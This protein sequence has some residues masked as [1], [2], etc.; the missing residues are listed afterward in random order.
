MICFSVVNSFWGRRGVTRIFYV[1]MSKRPKILSQQELQDA[2]N[3][4]VGG[5]VKV[6]YFTRPDLYDE[7]VG[8]L[9]IEAGAAFIDAADRHGN[10]SRQNI[11]R[12]GAAIVGV[13][14]VAPPQAAAAADSAPAP[15]SRP[16]TPTDEAANQQRLAIFQ[17]ATRAA[18]EATQQRAKQAAEA[19]Q[20][21]DRHA[22]ATASTLQAAHNERA[23]MNAKLDQ[24]A[25]MVSQLVQAQSGRTTSPTNHQPA[26]AG[27]L[28]ALQ[29]SADPGSAAF[30]QSPALWAAVQDTVLVELAWQRR[31]GHLVR[32]G[33]EDIGAVIASEMLHLLSTWLREPQ[34]HE[35]AQIAVGLLERQLVYVTNPRA[36]TAFSA[37]LRGTTMAP[38]YAKAW[39]A[40]KPAQAAAPASASA[41]AAA[42]RPYSPPPPRQNTRGSSN[43]V[44]PQLWQQLPPDVQEQIRKLRKR[45]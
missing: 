45:N 29:G 10:V 12:E 17:Q 1:V 5:V 43:R 27:G 15:D 16:G 20:D 40:V 19:K 42:S 25:A 44:P 2:V 37:S 39:E 11:M 28:V 31:Y 38:Q 7:L 21:R 4:L 30:A 23:H 26:V 8:R 6:T 36:A 24:L 33:S 13:V 3:S 32:P 14:A 41:P 34:S 22:A 18:E 9:T 35:V